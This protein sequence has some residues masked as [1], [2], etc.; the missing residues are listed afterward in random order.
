MKED[1]SDLDLNEPIPIQWDIDCSRDRIANLRQ[2]VSGLI[3]DLYASQ[4]E[5]EQEEE[6][7]EDYLDIQ[8]SLSK[9]HSPR[10][11]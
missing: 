10:V 2:E 5:L 4:R 7:L 8:N 1:F 11:E 9:G 3:A 6:R